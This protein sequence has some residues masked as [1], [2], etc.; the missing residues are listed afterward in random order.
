LKKQ[1]VQ[2]GGVP[3][4]EE[5]KSDEQWCFSNGR[6]SKVLNNGVSALRK[7]DEG[8]LVTM[9]QQREKNE[10]LLVMVFQQ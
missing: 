1:K 5:T 3:A 8:L 6:K 9:F 7:N 4:S 2:N 10:K